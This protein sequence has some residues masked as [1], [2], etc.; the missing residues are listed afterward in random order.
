MPKV[1]AGSSGWSYFRWKPDFYPA[2]LA[3]RK[4]LPDYATRLNSVEVNDTFRSF[5][6]EKLLK[7]WTGRLRDSDSP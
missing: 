5:P 6:T 2:T 3:S 1:Y 7:G 4:F